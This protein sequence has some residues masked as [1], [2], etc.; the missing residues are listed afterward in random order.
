MV[1]SYILLTAKREPGFGGHIRFWELDCVDFFIIRYDAS[2]G[3]L[4]PSSMVYLISGE[5]DFLFL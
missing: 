4:F 1:L 2:G 3:E 5:V